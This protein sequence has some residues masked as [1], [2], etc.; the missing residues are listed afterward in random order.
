[1]NQQIPFI[2]RPTGNSPAKQAA[3][4]TIVHGSKCPFWQF[5]GEKLLQEAV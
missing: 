5:S 2:D 1:M 4:K 3:W